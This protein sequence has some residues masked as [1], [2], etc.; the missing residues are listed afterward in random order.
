MSHF[1]YTYI[2]E[3]MKHHFCNRHRHKSAPNT[4]QSQKC[5]MDRVACECHSHCM[6]LQRGAATRLRKVDRWACPP[7]STLTAK[8]PNESCPSFHLWSLLST[9]SLFFIPVATTSVHCSL[10]ATNYCES[11]V[12]R[13]INSKEKVSLPLADSA[14]GRIFFM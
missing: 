14:P 12:E 6:P 1:W 5:L 11:Y 4:I 3:T 8:W 2:C 9:H 10:P 13:I 7:P